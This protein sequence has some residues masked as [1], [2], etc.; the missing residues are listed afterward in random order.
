[1][2]D[3]DDRNGRPDNIYWIDDDDVHAPFVPDLILSF[4]AVSKMFG[5]SK[6]YLLYLEVIGLI[7]RRYRSG[8][9]SVYGWADCER[10]VFILKARRAGLSLRDV[11][12]VL[13]ATN[14]NLPAPERRR[15][16]SRCLMLIDRLQ[17]QRLQLDQ[18]F[19]ELEHI[20][21]LL[22]T[23]SDPRDSDTEENGR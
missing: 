4:S 16:L 10:I 19:G 12:P 6:I 7:R 13:R 14:Y 8:N 3:R 21:T 23:G 17:L 5:I 11:A 22:T 18:A 1:M 9:Q 20:C 2:T 15:G